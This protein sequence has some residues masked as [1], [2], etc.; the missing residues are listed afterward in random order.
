MGGGAP[1]VLPHLPRGRRAAAAAAE[2]HDA[3]G[4]GGQIQ[5]GGTRAEGQ[6]P[7]ARPGP[8]PCA[9]APVPHR[10][11]AGRE[12]DPLLPSAFWPPAPPASWFSLRTSSL[13]GPFCSHIAFLSLNVE[14][15]LWKAQ[16]NMKEK[17]NS[18]SEILSTTCYTPWRI[19]TYF[20]F[21]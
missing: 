16:K 21:L 9:R 11:A 12:G 8:A 20:L 10:A 1:P 4:L 2:E 17:K 13:P 15:V 6:G 18:A 5:P 19:S 14:I 7:S 3:A